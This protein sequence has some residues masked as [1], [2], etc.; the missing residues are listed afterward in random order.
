ML[1]LNRAALRR[2]RQLLFE[3]ATFQVHRGQRVGVVG[4]NGC[5]KSS[6]FALLTGD[7]ETDRG[8]VS[9][10]RDAVIASVRQETPASDRSALDTVID[11]D[12][13]LRQVLD[14]IAEREAA[15]R[16]DELQPLLERMEDIDGFTAETRAGKLLHGLGF[17][18]EDAARPVREFSGG[19]RM[20]LN[21]AQALMCRSDLLLLDEPTNHLDLDA[22]IWLQTWLA[23]YRGTLLLISHDREFLDSFI[24]SSRRK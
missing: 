19:W 17:S 9:V 10:P 24:L 13:E 4:R 7:L 21:L 11:G 12:R 22:V 6:L 14:G 8:D 18:P 15:G 1:A 2:G 20:R 16:T 3:D 5:G 23:T